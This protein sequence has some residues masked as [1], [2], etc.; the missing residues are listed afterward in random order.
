MH[1]INI[2]KEFKTQLITFLDELISQFPSEG[3]LVI[4]RIFIANQ[5]P[6][7][8]AMNAF[9]LKINTNDQ[10]LKKMAKNRDEIFFLEHNVFDAIGKEKANHFK[11]LWCSGQLD[12]KDKEVIWNWIDVFIYL[13]EK[14]TKAIN[15]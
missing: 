5:V 3:D 12:S 15:E 9:I 8:D 7:K 13:A 14:Y 1:E 4:F 10:E 6:I 11:T 2:L